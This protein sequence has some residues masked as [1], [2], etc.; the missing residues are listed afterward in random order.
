MN[1]SDKGGLIIDRV[2]HTLM[3]FN[4]SV[5]MSGTTYRDGYTAFYHEERLYSVRNIKNGIVSL[6]YANSTYEAIDKVTNAG[7]E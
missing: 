3:E 5:N 2:A 1:L 4:P 7:G 6:V